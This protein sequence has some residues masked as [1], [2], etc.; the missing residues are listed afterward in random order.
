MHSLDSSQNFQKQKQIVSREYIFYTFVPI[1][2]PKIQKAFA[3]E[4]NENF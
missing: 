4:H 1:C 3:V 2:K